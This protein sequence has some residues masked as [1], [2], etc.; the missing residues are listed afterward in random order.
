MCSYIVFIPNKICRAAALFV[1]ATKDLD[2]CSAAVPSLIL[3]HT[4]YNNCMVMNM[5]RALHR[6]MF[7]K[8]FI[9]TTKIVS[10]QPNKINI[11][12]TK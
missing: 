5:L 9:Y 3:L 8:L 11:V 7:S 2:I 1:I 12:Q 10:S 4:I 6:S